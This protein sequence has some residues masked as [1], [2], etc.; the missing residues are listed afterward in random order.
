MKNILSNKYLFFILA[1]FGLLYCAISLVNHYNFRTYAYD[2]GLVNNAIYDYAHLRWNDC[3]LMQPQFKN[4][5]EDHF[6]LLQILFSPLYY[7]LGTYTMLVVQ[8]VAVL[9]GAYGI[10]RYF[11]IGNAH[12]FALL[13]VIHFLTAWGVFSALA[14]DYHDNVL[15]AMAVPWLFYYFKKEKWLPCTFAFLY[16]LISKE[17]MAL[18]MGFIAL[19]LLLE[20]FK[21]ARKRNAALVFMTTSFVYFYV[22]VGLLMPSLAVEHRGYLHFQ[23]SALG[24]SFEDVFRFLI[25]HPIKALELLFINHLP[26]PGFNQ[27]KAELHWMVLASGG[28]CL[29]LRPQYLVMLLPIYAQKMWN[30]D[31]IKWGISYHYSVE[32]VP[33]LT[34]AL[35]S[36]LATIRREAFKWW[37]ASLA[38]VVS[39]YFSIHKIDRRTA[40]F[41]DGT[42]HRFYSMQHYR[43]ENLDVDSAHRMIKKLIPENAV[44][45]AHQQVVPHLAFRDMIYLFPEIRDAEYIVIL[46]EQVP[47]PLTP[48]Q[49][50]EEEKKLRASK[51]WRIL[52]DAGN[53]LIF[54]KNNSL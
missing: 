38:T 51:E 48:Q 11:T 45:S 30:D 6:T 10:Y 15:G 46:N 9:F 7:I 19:G 34:L 27:V 21:S 1:F 42:R 39:I 41:Y 13:A 31:V 26:N 29:L 49:L 12:K 40:P 47:Y 16:I 3:M 14:F 32:F 4:I 52:Y 23:Y 8:I 17:N 18:W 2:L 54:K 53:L 28:Y 43:N 20:N 44:V 50:L 5:L 35:F 33:V 37:A 36:V 24:K 22:V 25:S